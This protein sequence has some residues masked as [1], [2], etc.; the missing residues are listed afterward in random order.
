MTLINP[1]APLPKFSVQRSS[2]ERARAAAGNVPRRIALAVGA[3]VLASGLAFAPSIT[4]EGPAQPKEVIDAPLGGVSHAVAEPGDTY[5]EL[6]TDVGVPSGQVPA[7][8]ED[9]Q[10]QHGVLMAGDGVDIPVPVK[11]PQQ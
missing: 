5:F 1:Q 10:D 9:L 2:L 8:A 6:A 7:V 4:S 3:T 11:Q